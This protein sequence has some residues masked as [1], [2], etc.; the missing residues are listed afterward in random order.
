ME[1]V[2]LS[3]LDVEDTIFNGTVLFVVGVDDVFITCENR[4]GGKDVIFFF[5]RESP[6]QSRL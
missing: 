1:E 6:P 2:V 4:N 5:A 3:T